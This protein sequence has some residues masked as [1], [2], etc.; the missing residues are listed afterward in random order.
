M[1]DVH[2]TT[3]DDALTSF[4]E[5]LAVLVKGLFVLELVLQPFEFP[6]SCAWD[7]SHNEI[8]VLV[9]ESEYSSLLTMFWFF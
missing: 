2:I 5:L 8:K 4:F 7:I 6:I 1:T 9:F 3:D